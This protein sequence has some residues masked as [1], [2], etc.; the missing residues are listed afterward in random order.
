MPS[1]HG[2]NNLAGNFQEMSETSP[3][4]DATSSPI[5]GWV[6]STGSTNSAHM[7]AGTTT[8][9]ANFTSTTPPDGTLDGTTGDG[10]RTTGVYTGNFAAAAWTFN[11]SVIGVTQ[12]GT[13]DGAVVYR[14]FRG[15]NADGSGATQITGA[16]Q[17]ASTVTNL[18][19]TA[20]TST[21][22]LSPGAFSVAGE[23]I[24][25][26]VAWLRT[27]AGGHTT[28]DVIFRWGNTGT[29]VISAAFTPTATPGIVFPR[30]TWQKVLI[31]R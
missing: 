5:V 25:V 18:T 1:W 15:A 13:Q 4:T 16:A 11:F 17:T 8:P 9:A 26:Q 12:A 22:S 29:R 31:R 3:G 21:H 19:T 7:D 6:V 28:T 24:F 2:T 10:F 14:L 23:Y 27:G 20:Q 30:E